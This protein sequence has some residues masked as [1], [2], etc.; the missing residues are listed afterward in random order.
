MKSR[1]WAYGLGRFF[2]SALGSSDDTP[3][4]SFQNVGLFLVIFLP[5]YISGKFGQQFSPPNPAPTAF[6][7][8]AGIAYAALFLKGRRA[9]PA[10]FAG[11]FFVDLFSLNTAPY[12]LGTALGDTLEA[13]IAVALVNRLANGINAFFNP[14]D[15]LRYVVL[16]GI[17]PT[18]FGATC[19]VSLMCLHGEVQWANFWHSWTIWW[20]GD[21]LAAIILAPFLIL[22]L[23]HRHNALSWSEMLEATALLLGLTAV[24]ILNFG[25][26]LVSW[27]PKVFLSIPFLTWAAVRFCPLEVSGACLVMSGFTLWG[28]LQGY[29]PF[30]T[31]RTEP[32]M[33]VGNVCVYSVMTMFV[34]AALFKQ[35]RDIEKLYALKFG[36]RNTVRDKDG[37]TGVSDSIEIVEKLD[38]GP[39]QPPE[40]P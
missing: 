8:P 12:A 40:D 9:L 29:G 36:M 5:Y 31:A 19:G 4:F 34:A 22:L 2:S 35:R 20:V 39:S 7:P 17:I 37:S 33:L 21:L 16:A 32:L 25:P 30:A 6:W 13:I 11:A 26:P 18:A 14:R 27:I 28:S 23:G 24:C 1:S 10:I 38:G 3:V 15:V